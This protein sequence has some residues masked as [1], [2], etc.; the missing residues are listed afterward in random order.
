MK[1]NLETI[2]DLAEQ[3]YFPSV[4]LFA[5]PIIIIFVFF[6]CV[7]FSEGRALREFKKV[8]YSLFGV[9]TLMCIT[10][11]FNDFRLFERNM[12]M[13]KTGDYE[14]LRG[15]IEGFNNKAAYRYQSITINGKT[16]FIKN[17][18]SRSYSGEFEDDLA[19]GD[20]VIV[21]YVRDY[22]G[23]VYISRSNDS[24]ILLN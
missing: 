11:F 3:G 15:S 4:E 8:T 5:F 18:N 22:D 16:L 10:I 24:K 17:R 13:Y 1:S 23:I 19:K 7:R 21:K 2:Y 9:S 12:T 20:L 14:V 6:I